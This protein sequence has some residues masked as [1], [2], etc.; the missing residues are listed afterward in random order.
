MRD[1]TYYIN[2]LSVNELQRSPFPVM[3]TLISYGEA[4]KAVTYYGMGVEGKDGD[5]MYDE[6]RTALKV[7]KV[8]PVLSNINRVI[9]Y[10]KQV[11]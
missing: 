10:S 11:D 3:R 1:L 4:M 7:T 2:P 6:D 9:Y 8:L 5:L